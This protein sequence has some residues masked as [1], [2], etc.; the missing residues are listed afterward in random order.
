M[1]KIFTII[2]L[3]ATAALL[4]ACNL[5]DSDDEDDP[6]QAMIQTD[7]D[8]Y[9]TSFKHDVVSPQEEFR[10]VI[11][12]NIIAEYQ[13]NTGQTVYLIN[14]MRG[15]MPG[16]DFL[17]SMA[18]VHAENGTGTETA[19]LFRFSGGPPSTSCRPGSEPVKVEPGEVRTDTIRVTSDRFSLEGQTSRGETSLDLEGEYQIVYSGSSCIREDSVFR[20]PEE[21]MFTDISQIPVSNVFEVRVE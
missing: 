7:R 11:R 3:I 19:N 8:V 15:Q 16:F 4:A 21:C 9:I 20:V 18:I 14:C 13:N 17:R 5:L 1:K 6:V 10:F 12:F 2:A